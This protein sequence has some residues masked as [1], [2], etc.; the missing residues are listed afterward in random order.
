MGVGLALAS[1]VVYG[2]V[3]FAG[4]ILSRR[5]HYAF[6]A[7]V[8]QVGGGPAQLRLVVITRVSHLPFVS[9]KRSTRQSPA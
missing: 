5:V 1:A 8:G 6:V 9:C 3:D 4:G 2:I 7:W